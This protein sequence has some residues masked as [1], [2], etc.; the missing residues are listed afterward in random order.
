VIAAAEED[1]EKYAFAVDDIE[2]PEPEPVEKEFQHP[3]HLLCLKTFSAKV[4]PRHGATRISFSWLHSIMQALL[5]TKHLAR[6]FSVG[7]FDALR[8]LIRRNND[9]LRLIRSNLGLPLVHEVFHAAASQSKKLCKDR[10]YPEAKELVLSKFQELYIGLNSVWPDCRQPLAQEFFLNF[11]RQLQ[12]ELKP[13]LP[14]HPLHPFQMRIFW[15]HT[16]LSCDEKAFGERTQIALDL[17]VID[18]NK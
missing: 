12:L 8:P 16:C 18:Y 9:R 15:Q 3:D 5:G 17:T 2:L 10:A 11:I 7:S 4:E 1:K 6:F 14:A 13:D